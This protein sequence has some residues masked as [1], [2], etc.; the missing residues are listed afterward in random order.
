MKLL[1]FQLREFQSSNWKE[2]D[3]NSD[4]CVFYSKENSTGKTTLMRAIL[5]TL[6]FSIPNTEL[7]KFENYEFIL[8]LSFN[9]KT[10]TI[11]RNNRIISINNT[12]FDLPVEQDAAHTFLFEISNPEILS[13]LLG[14]IYFD[15]E[16]GWTLLN[17]GTIIGTNR[18]SIESF[19]RGL[20]DDQSQESYEIVERLKALDK[21]IAKYNLMLN[22]AE[23]QAA[24]NQSGGSRVDYETFDQSLNYALGEKEL[25]L[26][27]IESEISR[28]DEIIKSNK[29]FSDYIECRKVF[30]KNPIDNTPIPVT[31]DTLLDYKDVQEVNQARRSMLVAK[32]NALKKQI[33][34]IT[35]QQQ[36]QL[37]L[38]H[39]PT[40]DEELTKRLANIQGI[41]A[42]E[43]KSLLNKLK[44]EKRDLN[45]VLN[46]KTKSNNPWI[47]EACDII[48]KYSQELNIP[49]DYRIDI[50][51]HNLKEK[52]G[53]ILHK[54]VFVYKLAY[55]ELLRKK[56][57]YALPIFCDS[58]SGRE[59][60]QSTINDMMRIL[61]R[62]FSEHQLIIASIYTYDNVIQKPKIINMNRSLFNKQ[63]LFD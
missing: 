34:E 52:S 54:M 49:L 43:V 62:D 41:S 29:S 48:Y 47:Y 5:Y 7:I 45:N 51:T 53:A 31:K 37:Q 42:V 58:P 11:V 55:I 61:N 13:N 10:Y 4:V 39:L 16:K 35:S 22:I 60:E 59:I 32:R 8:K 6:G 46:A 15:Q 27:E 3:L 40:M 21:Q 44:K 56:I 50:F 12:E 57:G 28:I 24:I 1:S 38:F 2:I 18:F 20:K 33:A 17:R 30:V 36:K 23:Y 9:E 25:I 19:F 26:S 14:T 63:S